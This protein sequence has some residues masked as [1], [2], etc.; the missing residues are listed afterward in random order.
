MEI[1]IETKRLILRL[2]EITDAKRVQTLAGNEEA[3]GIWY[4]INHYELTKPG[5]H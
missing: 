4:D 2:F 1:Q 3:A 5:N